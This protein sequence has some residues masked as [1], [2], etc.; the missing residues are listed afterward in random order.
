MGHPGWFM[1]DNS[2]ECFDA[3][4]AKTKTTVHHILGIS[5][6]GTNFYKKLLLKKGS[7]NIKTNTTV[8]IDIP[9]G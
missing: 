7:T 1:I 4:I 6:S 5:S 2:S 3:K 8:P 9:A